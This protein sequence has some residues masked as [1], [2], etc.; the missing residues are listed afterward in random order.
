MGK[1]KEEFRKRQA[2][3]DHR[4]EDEDPIQVG[5]TLVYTCYAVPDALGTFTVGARPSQC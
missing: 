1:A 3:P 5:H 2:N 4:T